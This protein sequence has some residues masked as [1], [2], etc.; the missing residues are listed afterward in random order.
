MSV[1][2]EEVGFGQTVVLAPKNLKCKPLRQASPRADKYYSQ[3]ETRTAEGISIDIA[4]KR[5]KY[6]THAPSWDAF[7]KLEN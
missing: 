1:S 5:A 7:F 3:T 6:H 2:A 4:L